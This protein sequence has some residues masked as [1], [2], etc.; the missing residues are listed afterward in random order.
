MI[1]FAVQANDNVDPFENLNRKM[2]S[3][4]MAIDTVAF[5][6][7]AKGYKA[8]TPDLV[9]VGVGNFFGNIR[10]LG[11][12]VNNVLQFKFHAASIDFARVAFNTTLGLGG[13]LDVA[14]GMGLKKNSEDFGQTLGAW[15][16]PSGP[17]LVLPFFGPGSLRDSPAS[18]VPLDAWGYT[19]HVPTRNIGYGTRL[20]NKRAELF[21]YEKLVTG[22]E[23]IFIRDAYL[24]IRQQAVN[25]GVVDESFDEDDF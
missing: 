1:S 19:D 25:D 8:L 7:L 18:F 9:E 5:K 12:L 2:Y 20:I 16:V 3:F 17:Y 24:G 21:E 11:T 22:D 15:G 10:D 13:V 6:P 4:N 23:Y 14:S